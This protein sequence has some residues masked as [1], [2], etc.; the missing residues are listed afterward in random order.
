MESYISVQRSRIDHTL[1]ARVVLRS[2]TQLD[3]PKKII[4]YR[5]RILR[6]D[7]KSLKSSMNS[8]IFFR[9]SVKQVF[10]KGGCIL[11]VGAGL[12]IDSTRDRTDPARDWIKPLSKRSNI[13]SGP[14][15]TYHPDIVGDIMQAPFLMSHVTRYLSSGSGTRSARGMPWQKSIAS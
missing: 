9:E 3:I 14:S 11:D 6:S 15:D 10:T 2:P 7:V 4:R 12:R 1:P 13:K 5:C 8:D